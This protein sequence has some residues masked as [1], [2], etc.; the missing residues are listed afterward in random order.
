M[1]A[2]IDLVLL[3]DQPV[4]WAHGA[5]V[6][7][8]GAGPAPL[9]AALTAH[10]RTH[11]PAAV[12]LWDPTLGPPPA[13]VPALLD[14]PD[15]VWHAGLALGTGGQ[16]AALDLV[17]PTWMLNADPPADRPAT[18]WRVDLRACLVRTEV[19]TTIGGVDPAFSGLTGAGLEAGHRWIAHGAR[20]R[21]EPALLDGATRRPAA[22]PVTTD[23]QVRFVARRFGPTWATYVALRTRHRRTGLATL[24]RIR[25]ETAVPAGDLVPPPAPPAPDGGP[26][27]SVV[28]PTV[29]RYPWLAPLLD[30]LAVQTRPPL[31]VLVV[32]QTPPDRREPVT[33]GD[34]DRVRVLTMDVAGQCRSRNR[35]LAAAR[36]EL[37][38][39]LDDDDEIPPDLIERLV[40]RWAQLGVDAVSGV[41]PEP[42]EGDLDAAFR[43]F[44][45]SDVFP[46]N[47][48][49]LRAEA[50]A[51]S[52][53]F[54][55]AFDRGERAD[56]DLGV[57]LYLAG[58]RLVLDP[59]IRVVHHHAPRGGLRTHA[60]R[61]ATYRASR[62]S[63]LARHTLAPT[64]VYLWR[65]H[66]RPDQVREALVLRVLGTFS[67]RGRLA[68]R[69]A[70]AL[71]QVVLLPDTLRQVR[72]ADA[73][74]RALLADHPTIPVWDP[75]AP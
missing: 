65:R 21:H 1:S 13:A 70:R 68:D 25:G 59:T 49:L 51:H 16:P 50:L 53:L 30:Q 34:P 48:T 71:V 5:V 31:E 35:A 55:L 75:P 64:E 6:A 11:Q 61:V 62:S 39:F 23:D 10:L 66:H 14:Q 56:H 8:A 29:D 54:D 45:P 17:A 60:A 47:N 72:D 58:C 27:V 19:L 3:A 42:G 74:A 43:R 67:R 26:T 15:D 73:A 2:V 57:R 7:L 41:A 12:L 4:D 69:L 52:G 18:S 24:A 36:G 9:A 44:R 37:V 32:D 38:L 33:A 63:L 46:T 22:P 28:V 20:C 40:D